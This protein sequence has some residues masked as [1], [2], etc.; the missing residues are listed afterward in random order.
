[1]NPN[2]TQGGLTVQGAADRAR[3]DPTTIRDAISRGDLTARERRILE[4][5]PADVDAW[6][7][8]REAVAK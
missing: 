5:Q 2:T 7:T 4:L 3:V 8:S 6:V 1:M